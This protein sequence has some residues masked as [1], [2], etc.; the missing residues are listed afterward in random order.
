MPHTCFSSFPRWHPGALWLPSSQPKSLI[1]QSLPPCDVYLCEFQPTLLLSWG[2]WKLEVVT[3]VLYIKF[4]NYS[5]FDRFSYS[6]D[7]CSP[8]TQATKQQGSQE[9][10]KSAM[11]ILGKRHDTAE[12][13]VGRSHLKSHNLS[14]R[15]RRQRNHGKGHSVT[16]RNSPRKHI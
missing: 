12:T 15:L 16:D 13:W 6:R 3:V 1:G 5:L 11:S 14:T 4:V 7:V 10:L 2:S 8:H 9:N